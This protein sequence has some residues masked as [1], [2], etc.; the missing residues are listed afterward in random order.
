VMSAS[1]T[2]RAGA[3]RPARRAAD[4]AGG[5]GDQRAAAG[6]GK[7]C[8]AMLRRDCLPDHTR[9]RT[10]RTHDF[11]HR[12]NGLDKSSRRSSLRRPRTQVRRHAQVAAPPKP[13]AAELDLLRCCGRSGRATVK[14]V[15]EARA[16]TRPT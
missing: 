9:A 1:T 2:S 4:A 16:A 8:H 10:A 12:Q 15:H 14:D 7:L 11:R 13:T 3:R 5:A 6:E